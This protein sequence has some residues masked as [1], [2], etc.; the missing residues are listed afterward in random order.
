MKIF[1][2]TV[3][4]PD[5]DEFAGFVIVAKSKDRAIRYIKAGRGEGRFLN[6]INWR[7]G[8]KIKEIKASDYHKRTTIILSDY[9]AG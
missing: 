6:D 1:L 3:N 2:I 7:E 5:Y 9:K 4:E 8:Y